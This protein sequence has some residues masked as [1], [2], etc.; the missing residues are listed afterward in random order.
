WIGIIEVKITITSLIFVGPYHRLKQTYRKAVGGVVVQVLKSPPFD[1]IPISTG[2]QI[3]VYTR[4]FRIE[5]IGPYRGVL[6]VP[7]LS[8]QLEVCII[9]RKIR[10]QYRAIA[11]TDM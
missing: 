9:G 6:Y 4:I 11:V 2:I 1:A 10:Q 5:H 7:N 8:V 3:L